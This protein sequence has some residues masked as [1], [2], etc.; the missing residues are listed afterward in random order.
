M[1]LR[2]SVILCVHC[3]IFRMSV[4]NTN[5]D[6]MVWCIVIMYLYCKILSLLCTDVESQHYTVKIY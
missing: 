4:L 5:Y 2:Q 6:D 1:L 3:Y